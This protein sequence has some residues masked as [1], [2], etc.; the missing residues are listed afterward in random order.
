[1]LEALKKSLKRISALWHDRK[2]FWRFNIVTCL[3]S[4]DLAILAKIYGTDKYGEHFYTGHYSEHLCKLR[5][6]RLKI[7]E[8]GVGGYQNPD[9]GGESLRMWKRYFPKSDIYSIDIYDKRKFQE[10]RIK[11]FQGD[12]SDEAFLKGL[13]RHIGPLN[14]IIDD[15]SHINSHVIASFKALFPF[16][17]EGGIYVVEDTQ[18]AYWPKFGG[19]SED[20][21]DPGTTMNFFKSLTDELNCQE[22][23]I[24]DY[25]PSDFARQIVSIHFYHNLIFVHKGVND[26]PSNMVEKGKLKSSH[27]DDC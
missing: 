20:F 4:N 2:R 12:Q 9:A 23:L 10:K 13:C 25:T 17:A 24:P 27:T 22:F 11:I 14:I 18:T 19:N 6:K 5:K 15:G 21:N 1:M 7:L 3:R 16:L 8:I 26:E